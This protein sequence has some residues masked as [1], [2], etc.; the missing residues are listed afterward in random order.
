[1]IVFFEI[2]GVI[3]IEWV[4]EDQTVNAKY[5]LEFLIMLREWVKKKRSELWKKS[6]ILHQDNTPAHDAHAMKQFL[7][8]KC[9]PVLEYPTYTPDLIPCDLSCSTKRK[10]HWK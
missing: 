10:T 3:M 2:R 1:M 9:I 4:P 8:N 7:A 6:W 5:Y